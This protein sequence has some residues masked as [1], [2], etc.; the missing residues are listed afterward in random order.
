MTEK[1][2][3]E[4]T[5]ENVNDTKFSLISEKDQ[6]YAGKFWEKHQNAGWKT[7]E[8]SSKKEG[9]RRKIIGKTKLTYT[10]ELPKTITETDK[11]KLSVIKAIAAKEGYWVGL[12]NFTSDNK[13]QAPILNT[14]ILF[15]IIKKSKKEFYPNAISSVLIAEGYT[16]EEI[17]RKKKYTLI[18]FNENEL[19]EIENL[20]D[21]CKVTLDLLSKREPLWNKFSSLLEEMR[22]L[23]S[24]SFQEIKH[25]IEDKNALDSKKIRDDIGSPAIQVPT[26]IKILYNLM[27]VREELERHLK[28][29]H[30]GA[31]KGM[32]MTLI[33]EPVENLLSLLIKATKK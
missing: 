21:V 16:S 18:K 26:K 22:K 14:N 33:S 8:I 2:T 5:Q 27:M 29:Y 25:I 13:M 24:G 9:V 6:E 30:G 28:M 1:L 17:E 4:L 7:E 3:Y 19:K 32:V 31:L 15:T 20:I 23:P 11:E 12:F 10:P